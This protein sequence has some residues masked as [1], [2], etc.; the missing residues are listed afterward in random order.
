MDDGRDVAG[1]ACS[2]TGTHQA[3]LLHGPGRTDPGHRHRGQHG[4]LQRRGQRPHQPAALPPVRPSPQLQPRGTGFG[5]EGSGHSPFPG[6]VPPLP[7]E[8]AGHSVFRR[9]QR[10][11]HQPHHQRRATAADGEPGFAGVFPGPG[12]PALPGTG[13]RGGGGPVRSGAGRNPRLS[14][15]GAELRGGPDCGGPG[16]G[17]GRR[18]APGSGGDASGIRVLRRGPLGSAGDRCRGRRCRFPQFYRC[19]SPG[20][21]YD[22]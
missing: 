2:D 13:L 11:R 4:H 5:S 15:L 3:P 12:R 17:D 6:L 9:F 16:G 10:R 14:P 7:G 18:P 19:C 22:H 21:R 1:S 20:G 8:R